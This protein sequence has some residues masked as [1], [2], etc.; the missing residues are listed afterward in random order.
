MWLYFRSHERNENTDENYVFTDLLQELG[1]F[2]RRKANEVL[3]WLGERGLRK[4]RR[5][6]QRVGKR[7]EKNKVVFGEA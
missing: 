1:N 3:S 6:K 7:R 5:L 2:T 4:K